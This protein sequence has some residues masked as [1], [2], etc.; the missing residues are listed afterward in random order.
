MSFFATVCMLQTVKGCF[1]QTGAGTS[2]LIDLLVTI[3][4]YKI[5]IIELP[6]R[7]SVKSSILIPLWHWSI[8]EGFNVA[9]LYLI[10]RDHTL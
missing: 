4:F 9:T 3:S 6:H 2:S 8:L 7:K 5:M 10:S 1:E